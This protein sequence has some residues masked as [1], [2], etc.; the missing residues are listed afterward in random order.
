MY[1]NGEIEL[2]P[3]VN[4]AIE[5]LLL[6]NIAEEINLIVVNVKESNLTQD[7]VG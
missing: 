2:Y 5:E 3:L 4:H 6:G 1:E 7:V